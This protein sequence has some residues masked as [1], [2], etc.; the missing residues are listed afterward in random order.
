M[1][2]PADERDTCCAEED[3]VSFSAENFEVSRTKPESFRD[4]ESPLGFD[5]RCISR[6]S[7]VEFSVTAKKVKE[8]SNV[9]AENEFVESEKKGRFIFSLSSQSLIPTR[10]DQTYFFF[11]SFR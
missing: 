8:S 1:R 9:I 5:F 4:G 11:F 7:P 3:R 2:F 10:G 6:I